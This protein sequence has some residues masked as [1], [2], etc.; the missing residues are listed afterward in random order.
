MRLFGQKTINKAHQYAA[1]GRRTP[2]SGRR[3]ASACVP[4]MA[5]N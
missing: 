5:Q 3:C 2:L 4:G 1:D